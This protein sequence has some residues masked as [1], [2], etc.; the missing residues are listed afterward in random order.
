MQQS[1]G[2]ELSD[3][4]KTAVEIF[5]EYG[6]YIRSLIHYRIKNEPEAE[7]LFQDLFLSLVAKAIPPSV[8]NVKAYLCRA[9]RNHILDAVR[10]R[11][12]YQSAARMYAERQ[13]CMLED[14][15]ETALMAADETKN[16]FRIIRNSLS[17]R[18]ASAV[19]LRYKDN[20]DIEE[21]AKRL[22]VNS[23][24]VS[25]YVSIGLGKIRRLSNVN[26]EEIQPATASIA[27]VEGRITESVEI[28]ALNVSVGEFSPEDEVAKGIVELYR[29]LN[30][31][32]ISSGGSGLVIDDWQSFVRDGV[33]VGVQ[34]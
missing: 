15:A 30:S 16:V 17:Q 1:N 11:D 33:P 24:S 12:R 14:G 28:L 34:R 5:E 13:E 21:I 32:Y 3:N 29:A 23:R 25:R 7:D 26:Q 31:Y 19:T 8:K 4:M 22:K 2:K 27:K 9:I 6:D 18:E 20:C 10:R